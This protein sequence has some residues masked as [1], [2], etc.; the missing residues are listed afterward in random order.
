MRGQQVAALVAGA[1]FVTV[2]IPED[3]AFADSNRIFYGSLVVFIIASL[4]AAAG[5]WLGAHL[6][7]RRRLEHLVAEARALGEAA[8]SWVPA[9]W[10]SGQQG[11]AQRS[12]SLVG[13]VQEVVDRQGSL[14]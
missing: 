10:I 6:L 13:V 2:G 8:V 14:E 7:I 5:T 12:P 11:E 1:L 4:L 3:I 9:P